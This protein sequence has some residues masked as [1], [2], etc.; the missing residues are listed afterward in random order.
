MGIK[1]NANSAARNIVKVE[2][3]KHTKNN[4]SNVRKSKLV[5][6]VINEVSKA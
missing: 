6:D 1:P 5:E 4:M 2:K 3:A